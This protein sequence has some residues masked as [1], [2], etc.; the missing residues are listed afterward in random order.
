MNVLSPDKRYRAAAACLHLPI[1]CFFTPFGAASPRRGSRSQSI[2]CA[3][4]GRGRARTAPSEL[5]AQHAHV[6]RVKA[7]RGAPEIAALAAAKAE[8]N[9]ASDARGPMVG[10]YPPNPPPDPVALGLGEGGGNRSP[11]TWASIYVGYPHQAAP[12]AGQTDRGAGTQ[13]LFDAG[14]TRFDPFAKRSNK[15]IAQAGFEMSSLAHREDD[16]LKEP[17]SPHVPGCPLAPSVDAPAP[18]LLRQLSPA[19]SLMPAGRT[20]SG[21]KKKTDPECG[22]GAPGTKIEMR[23]SLS[24]SV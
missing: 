17:L 20:V 10:L 18:H 11:S 22:F 8:R 1:F 19:A 23:P 14:A 7:A 16:R 3:G 12:R 5:K 24:A 13:D 15:M 21:E 6:P 2:R 9:D 4:E